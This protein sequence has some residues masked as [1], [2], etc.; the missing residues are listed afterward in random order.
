MVF[1]EVGESGEKTRSLLLLLIMGLQG[2]KRV[3]VISIICAGFAY[4]S[5]YKPSRSFLFCE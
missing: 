1:V 4:S 2:G 5:T 3:R